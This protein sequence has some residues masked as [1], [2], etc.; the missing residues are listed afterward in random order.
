MHEVLPYILHGQMKLSDDHEKLISVLNRKITPRGKY[1]IAVDGMTGS[2]KSGLSRYLAWQLDMP[3]IE[4]DML[5]RT[6]EEQP[7]YC[8]EEL[9]SLIQ[10]RHEL[11]RPVLIEGIFLLDTLN[12]LGIEPDYMIYVK[13]SKAN[14]GCALR[15]SLPEYLDKYEP[16][17]RANYVFCTDFIN[18]YNTSNEPASSSEIIYPKK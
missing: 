13:N 1:L 15:N 18:M 11:D 2:G 6:R 4:T 5:R 10:V 7:S 16:E 3:V 12:K 9:K 14:A 17:E 8:L